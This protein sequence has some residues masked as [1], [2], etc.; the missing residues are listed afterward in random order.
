MSGLSTLK[1]TRGTLLVPG[2]GAFHVLFN[3]WLPDLVLASADKFSQV[4]VL[5]SQFSN[6]V[7]SVKNLLQRTNV[8]CIARETDSYSQIKQIAEVGIGLDL[9][10]HYFGQRIEYSQKISDMNLPLIALRQDKGS[11]LSIS[12]IEVLSNLNNDISWSSKSLEHFVN[13]IERATLVVTDRLQIAVTAVMLGK[14][15][16]YLETYGDKIKNY[17]NFHFGYTNCEQFREIDIKYLKE[18][19][20][21]PNMEIEKPHVT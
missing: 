8:F 10:L 9:A 18:L 19:Q 20:P 12:E 21:V 6:Q 11:L 17:F 4:I 1:S 3:E 16:N 2:S 13:Q 14:K 15:L 7:D 5:P